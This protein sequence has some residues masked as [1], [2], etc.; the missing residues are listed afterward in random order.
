[1]SDACRRPLRIGLLTDGL[2]ERTAEGVA[3]IANGG[4]GVYIYNL[5]KHLGQ[6]DSVHEYVT[7]RCG[8]GTLDVYARGRN[9]AHAPLRAAAWN[10]LARWVDRPYARVARDLG[11]DLL[12][13]PNQFGGAFLSRRIKR[14]LTLHDITPLLYPRFH[15]ARS[16]LGYRLLLRASLRAADHVIVDASH[17]A[18]ELVARGYASAERISVIPLG[19]ADHCRAG[20]RSAEFARRYDVPDPFILTVGVL[21]PRKNHVCLLRALHHLHQSGMRVGAVLVG[22]DGW[23]WRDPLAAPDLAYL[24]PWVRIYRNVPD[25]DLAEFYTRAAAFAYPSLYEGFGLPIVEAMACGT[26]VVSS[27]ASCLPEVAGGAALL[28][29]P[30]DP[31]DFAAKLRAVL[32]DAALRE[33]LRAAGAQRSRELSWRRTA[34]QTV[35]VYER[36]C[37][38]A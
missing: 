7:I 6:I 15:P 35:A 13:Y 2:V 24:R 8:A 29:D 32:C 12:H 22:R 16:V 23:R 4:V 3:Q 19:V 18:G 20:V 38:G 37:W 11:L 21:E 34:E 5:V 14:V 27:H 26:P 33:R 17:T 10:R 31:A 30:H 28:A 1:M 9:A 25:S 36:V